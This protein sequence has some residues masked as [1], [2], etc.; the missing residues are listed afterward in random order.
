M[1]G[2]SIQNAFLLLAAVAGLWFAARFVIGPRRGAPSL[3]QMF[4]REK[5][6]PRDGIGKE[7]LTTL[8]EEARKFA[9]G[10]PGIR[11]LILAGPF[12]AKAASA[13]SKVTLIALCEEPRHYADAGWMARWAYPARGHP[14][15][16]HAI[17]DH[18]DGLR[19]QITL[20]G[21]PPLVVHFERLDR[22][23]AP[24][25]VHQALLEGSETIDDPSGLAEKTRLNWVV[26]IRRAH[27]PPS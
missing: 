4:T 18:A 5:A 16:D 13:R 21:A 23:A 26:Q 24:A 25:A 7:A 10:E 11:G 22:L 27:I 15:I 19:H 6:S 17:E 2:L 9:V 20:R 1:A 14:V 8:I 3:R 12:A